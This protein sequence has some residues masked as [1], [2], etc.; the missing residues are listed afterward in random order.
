MGLNN[1]SNDTE[2]KEN[3]YKYKVGDVVRVIK[4]NLFFGQVG[5]ITSIDFSLLPTMRVAIDCYTTD[6]VR[7]KIDIDFMEKDIEKVN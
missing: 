4:N 7:R 5:E 2:I 3:V 6:G 1:M